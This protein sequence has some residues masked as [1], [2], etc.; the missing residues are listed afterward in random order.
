MQRYDNMVLMLI[1]ATKGDISFVCLIQMITLSL[2]P[3]LL[4]VL[5]HACLQSN[6]FAKVNWQDNIWYQRKDYLFL[7]AIMM[8]LTLIISIPLVI[9]YNKKRLGEILSDE[10]NIGFL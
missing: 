10:K 5:V 3:S 6:F 2:I 7:L 1:G 9:R 8:L 4:A